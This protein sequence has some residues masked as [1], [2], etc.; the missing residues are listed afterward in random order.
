MKSWKTSIF[1]LFF[2]SSI[3]YIAPLLVSASSGDGVQVL[4]PSDGKFQQGTVDLLRVFLVDKLILQDQDPWG[5]TSIQM[6]ISDN[7]YG[8]DIVNT[9]QFMSTD[10][11]PY[12]VIILAGQQPPS[13]YTA[14]GSDPILSK[15]SQFVE[16]GGVLLAHTAAYWVDE[17]PTLDLPGAPG[18]GIVSEDSVYVEDVSVSDPSHPIMDGLFGVVNDT[19]MDGWHVSAHGHFYNLPWNAQIIMV[20]G[21]TANHPGNATYVQWSYGR[22]IVVATRSPLEWG[23]NKGGVDDMR[24]LQNEIAFAQAYQSEMPVGG[25]ILN[26]GASV[27]PL[28]INLAY[29]LVIAIS[30]ATG[31]VLLGRRRT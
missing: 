31:A 25:T 3:I 18:L 20:E 15:L 23:Y 27:P 7:G 12:K 22:G 1:L 6:A 21:P 2:I 9:T 26:S 4:V 13:Y 19:N 30:I 14:I 8:Y 5:Y 17:P 11:T 29:V 10:L 28:N 16:S 24:P